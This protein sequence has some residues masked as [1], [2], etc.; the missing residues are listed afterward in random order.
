MADQT[1][2]THSR[3]HAHVQSPAHTLRT[4]ACTHATHTHSCNTRKHDTLPSHTHT[5]RR[6]RSRTRDAVRS[7]LNFFFRSSFR[8]RAILWWIVDC[9]PAAAHAHGRI[10]LSAIRTCQPRAATSTASRGLRTD[11]H[12]QKHG[13]RSKHS[14]LKAHG[15]ARASARRRPV[16]AAAASHAAAKQTPQRRPYPQR[17]NP[18]AHYIPIPPHARHATGATRAHAHTPP[19]RRA[20]EHTR[21]RASPPPPAGGLWHRTEPSCYRST[22]AKNTLQ[23]YD[24]TTAPGHKDAPGAN[25]KVG[26][27][28]PHVPP[29]NTGPTTNT[30]S[31]AAHVNARTP[32]AA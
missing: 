16:A 24:N 13:Q 26:G 30:F 23:K 25:N 4:R 19:L 8:T 28:T 12:T 17:Q 22:G 5:R 3:A 32:H 20:G 2:Q 31:G 10:K 9:A 18:P 29:T 11:A 14:L 6:C 27:Q 1:A 21:V 7:S 15:R